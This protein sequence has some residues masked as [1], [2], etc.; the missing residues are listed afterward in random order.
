MKPRQV[1]LCLLAINNRTINGLAIAERL[2]SHVATLKDVPEAT[3]LLVPAVM[4]GDLRM[5]AFLLKAGAD[6]NVPTKNPPL[7]IAV[8]QDNVEMVTL[9]LQQEGVLVNASLPSPFTIAVERRNLAMAKLLLE[10]P[11]LRI[12]CRCGWPCQ[13]QCHPRCD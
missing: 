7:A 11:G 3:S 6:V 8:R 4:Q 9:L 10:T 5:T 12:C 1:C 13:Q 2:H